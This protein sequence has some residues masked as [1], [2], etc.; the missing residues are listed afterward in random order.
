MRGINLEQGE[1]I[2]LASS[3]ARTTGANGSWVFVGG[4]RSHYTWLLDITASATDAADTLDVYI[5]VSFDGTNSAGNAVHFTQQAGDGTAASEIAVL[6]SGVSPAAIVAVT[7]DAA[8]TVIRPGFIGP[9]FRA[10]WAI[11]DSGDANSSHTFSVTG[12]A[13]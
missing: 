3:A 13:L 6:G 2:T 10:R 1:L 4:E 12:Y 9:Y 11:V 5:D 8:A 7:S